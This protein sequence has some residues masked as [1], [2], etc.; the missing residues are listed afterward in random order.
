[1]SFN[2][3]QKSVRLSLAAVL[4]AVPVGAALGQQN[5]AAPS[6][7]KPA[8]EKPSG[9]GWAVECTNPGDALVCK[10]VQNIFLTKTRQKL[11]SVSVSKPKGGKDL[12][13]LIQLPH[14]LFL[15]AGL[16]LKVDDKKPKELAV[17]T[18]D[19]A[20]CYAGS[21]LDQALLT[22]LKSGSV[23][24]IA[25]QNLQ[26]RRMSIPVPLKGFAAALKKI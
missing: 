2:P 8:T 25:F 24:Q 1:M 19:R 3:I 10:T 4:I 18:C 7:A 16:T 14:G 5:K 11:L 22:K 21:A 13:M 12:A 23:L 15:P 26:K 6:S 20:G 9:P 17:Q